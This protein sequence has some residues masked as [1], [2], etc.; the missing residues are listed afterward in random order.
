MFTSTADKPRGA[1]YAGPLVLLLILATLIW[2]AGDQTLRLEFAVLDF[3]QRQHPARPSQQVLLVDSSP[4]ATGT[5]LWDDPRMPAAI[6]QLAEAGAAAI[7]PTQPPPANSEAPDLRELSNLLELEQRA[8]GGSQRDEVALLS[9]QLAAFRAHLEAQAAVRDAL[10][11]ASHV[12]L[13]L[14]TVDPREPAGLSDCRRLSAQGDALALQQAPPARELLALPDYLC[15]SVTAAGYARFRPDPDGVVRETA[16]LVRSGEQIVPTLAL[17][18]LAAGTQQPSIRVDTA[19]RLWVGEQSIATGPGFTIY[20]RYYPGG[21]LAFERLSIEALLNGSVDADSIRGKVVLLGPL[22]QASLYRV[23]GKLGMR[24][25]VLA[26][27]SLSNL[28]QND[29]LL[30]PAWLPWV[31]TALLAVLAVAFLVFVPGLNVNG[32]ALTV[33]VL[34]CLLIG[35]EAYLMLAHGLWARFGLATLFTI[36]GVASL[37]ALRLLR[38]G[39]APVLASPLPQPAG[40]AILNEEDELD[41]AFSV[42]RQQ[43]PSDETKGKLYAIAVTH[44]RRKEYAKAERVLRYLA[45]IDPEYRGVQEKLKKLSGARRASEPEATPPRP[46]IKP[47]AGGDGVAG[48]RLGRYELQK[49]LG[50][51]AM[52]TVYL[53]IDTKINRKVAIKTIALAEEFSEE[54]LAQ[55]R[56]QFLREAESAGRLNHPN[57]IAIYDVGE[58]DEVAYLAMEYFE[59]KSL[60]QFSQPTHLLPPAWV[61][62]LGARAAEALH[63]AHAQKVVHRD[64]KPANIMYNAASDEL[65][66]TDFGIA[67]LTDTSR[68]KTGIILG[69]PSYMSPEQLSGTAVT[70]QSDLYSLGITLYQMLTGAP[71]FRAD[72]IPKLMDKIVNEHAPSLSEVRD[73]LPPCV[74]ELFERMLAKDP[75]DRYPNGRALAL[76]LRD[77]CSSFAG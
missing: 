22:D 10:S 37:G 70:G 67:R 34:G 28:L 76:A 61:L 62:E 11:R 39:P 64:I 19:G 56:A 69:T 15:D 17:A 60:A 43:P 36:L 50:R 44:G 8:R 38:A 75:E 4:G 16:L 73:D 32:A 23:P 46:A 71:P 47:V 66:L 7:V 65:K 52:A 63:Y 45:S 6:E 74:D 42:L 21:R 40:G 9:E 27:T 68:T 57:I 77:C 51:G 58:D 25:S 30:R 5:D 1:G 13:P 2:P 48:R 35:S 49:V 59:G 29:Y 14:A 20:N 18:A 55:A 24:G 72:S 53:G 33:I 54:D 26:A 31:E 3:F 12:A 41:L